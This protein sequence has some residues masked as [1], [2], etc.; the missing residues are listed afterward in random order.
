MLDS[1]K[2]WR[3]DRGIPIVPVFDG[4]RAVAVVAIVLFHVIFVTRGLVST[5]G[6][7][8]ATAIWGLLPGG[9]DALFIV[10]G[11]VIFLPTAAR[12]EFGSTTAFFVRRLARILPGYWLALAVALGL[13][14][15]I[16]QPA[17]LPAA[18]TVILHL[19]FLHT[20]ALLF[21]DHF[22]LGFGVIAPVWTLSLEIGFYIVL[23]VAAIAYARRPFVG[24]AAA[25]GVVLGWQTLALH[26]GTIA[27]VFGTTL[28]AAARQRIDTYYASQLPHWTL[29]LAAGMT[30]AQVYVRALARTPCAVLERRAMA[31]AAAALAMLTVVVVRAGESGA[32]NPGE[33]VFAREP[34]LVVFGYPV[35]LAT[36]LV[37]IALA[38]AWVQ[39]PLTGRAVRMLGDISYGVYLIHFAVIWAMLRL[40][41]LPRT[42]SLRD[43]LTWMALV[44]P[45]SVAY[46]YLSTR[47]VER[48][49]RGWARRFGRRAQD[50]VEGSLAA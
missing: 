24:L 14:V 39:R 22:P 42:G 44:L 45:I 23:P 34:A 36:L 50:G 15:A 3:G 19:L 28:S 13:L 32:L 5:R 18:R 2:E 40:T 49:A 17:G 41:K 27:G 30:G 25:A 8:M 26:A 43:L 48:P 7:W 20:P 9:L 4:Y 37:A 29:A 12:G 11:F 6:T 38:P 10:S 31:A 46:A 1:G 35:L 33:G 21:F 16:P 47:V